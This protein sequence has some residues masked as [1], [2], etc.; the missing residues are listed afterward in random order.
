MEQLSSINY[1]VYKHTCPSGKVYIGITGQNPSRRWK[2]GSGYAQNKYFY[3]AIQKYGWQNIK[4][5]ILF[6]SLTKEQAEAKEIELIAEYKSNNPEYGY[7]SAHGGGGLNGYK[8]TPEQKR[9]LS[10]AHKGQAA[11]NRGKKMSTEYRRK[12]A[13]RQA[14][15]KM[16]DSQKRKISEALKGRQHSAEHNAKVSAALKGT[17]FSEERK[18]KISEAR[19]GCIPWNKRN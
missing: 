15:K 3:N 8:F 19:K 4:H 13:E 6:D 1:I 12:C 14:G 2:N 16:S 7:N 5:E 17:I 9:Q 10:E 18:R 11:W